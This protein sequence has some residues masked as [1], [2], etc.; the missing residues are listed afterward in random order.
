M[1]REGPLSNS[2]DAKQFL[3]MKMRDYAKEVFAYLFF[4][5]KNRVIKFEELFIGSLCSAEVYPREV[6]KQALQHNAHAIIIAHN[7]PSGDTTPSQSDIEFTHSLRDALAVIDIK[8][9]DHLII[10]NDV[11]S[12]AEIGKL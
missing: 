1:E 5:A 8:V 6:V 9:L 12:L 2:D 10:G 11:V 4:D 3:L 7:H